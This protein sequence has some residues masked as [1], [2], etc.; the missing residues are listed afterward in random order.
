MN[1]MYIVIFGILWWVGGVYV[2]V[3]PF[4]VHIMDGTPKPN[5]ATNPEA[6]L[7]WNRLE[8]GRP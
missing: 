2:F 3:H 8:A 6:V 7:H 1:C 5:S 4:L